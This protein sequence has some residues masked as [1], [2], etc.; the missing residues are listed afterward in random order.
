MKPPH[1]ERH[2]LGCRKSDG[3]RKRKS[4]E[5]QSCP[6]CGSLLDEPP[7]DEG[8][9]RNLYHHRLFFKEATLAC[10]SWPADHPEFD[11]EGSV[12]QLRGW[13]LVEAGHCDILDLK[14]T[15]ADVADVAKL[16]KF[17][18]AGLAAA[19]RHGRYAK[20]V[21]RAGFFIWQVARS[22]SWD[23]IGE[24]EFRAIHERVHDV[25]ERE[26]FDMAA[27]LKQALLETKHSRQSDDKE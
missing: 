3:I 23:A 24:Q 5:P 16:A 20:I 9:K 25:Y 19:S 7:S 2:E 13:L 4:K 6:E 8:H 11:P 14:L 26:G 15:L 10:K 1:S 22:I 17:M 18:N 21:E 27:L 12:E